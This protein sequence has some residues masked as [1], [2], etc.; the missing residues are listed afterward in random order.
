MATKSLTPQTQQIE[1]ENSERF[2][3]HKEP[4]H[5]HNKD[6]LNYKP[7]PLKWPVLG[8]LFIAI[9]IILALLESLRHTLSLEPPGLSLQTPTSKFST[10][11]MV[12]QTGISTP[13]INI[14]PP[15]TLA[16]GDI[17]LP[18]RLPVPLPSVAP[19]HYGM[20]NGTTLQNINGTA[21]T[22][23]NTELHPS[24]ACGN[25][26]TDGLN[27]RCGQHLPPPN[28]A[29]V[30]KGPIVYIK[31]VCSVYQASPGHYPF[32]EQDS[33]FPCDYS[34]W[35]SDDPSDCHMQ[36]LQ[37]DQ[38]LTYQ[39]HQT[40]NRE[41]FDFGEG[42]TGVQGL[43]CNF[44][45]QCFSYPD[46]VGGQAI[47]EEKCWSEGACKGYPIP[48]R[49]PFSA[50]D[51]QTLSTQVFQVVDS[52][53]GTTWIGGFA[54]T[55]TSII[56]GTDGLST[57]VQT[58]SFSGSVSTFTT[59]E[60]ILI[61]AAKSAGAPFWTAISPSTLEALP[62]GI[63]NDPITLTLRN[64]FGVP[65]GTKTE[66]LETPINSDGS[67]T[68]TLTAILETLTDAKGI[69]TKTIVEFSATGSSVPTN[70]PV[71]TSA[72]EKYVSITRARYFAGSF[73]PVL[74]SVLLSI[75]IQLVDKNL[76]FML[77]FYALTRPKGAS[78]P[79]SLCMIPGGVVYLPR[80]FGLLY[81]FGEP[82]SF[83]SDLLVVLSAFLV[84]LSS[85][86]IGLKMHGE[87]DP[88]D[89]YGG[90]YYLELVMVNGP[91]RVVA[92]LLGL[93]AVV[94][95]LIWIF[96]CRAKSGVAD[97]PWSIANCAS[98]LSEELEDALRSVRTRAKDRYNDSSQIIKQL[99]G[100]SFG[101]RHYS[102]KHGELGYGIAVIED[103]GSSDSDETL[104]KVERP[105]STRFRVPC[106]RSRLVQYFERHSSWD[107]GVRGMLLAILCGLLALILYYEIRQMT[108]ADPFES[109]MDSQKFGVRFFFVAL[110][111]I[112]TLFWDNYVSRKSPYT[113]PKL[114][115]LG[116]YVWKLILFERNDDDATVPI[117]FSVSFSNQIGHLKFASHLSLP[118]AMESGA[119][120]RSLLPCCFICWD[121]IQVHPNPPL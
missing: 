21:S 91:S 53:T 115:L 62:P 120:P 79:D 11:S 119:A 13:K 34:W 78:A 37:F 42:W 41:T 45:K 76:K 84:S 105:G 43:N 100:K 56:T 1:S 29:S 92:A 69:P 18:L 31:A 3:R 25:S 23:N 8:S 66:Y 93:M 52:T 22:E 104:R 51:L 6:F 102:G 116:A 75:V 113:Y 71:V 117:S 4:I 60:T 39:I 101:L 112:V 7:I 58:T 27:R 85:E 26:I 107:H 9:C 19:R 47:E 103:S 106:K 15:C 5:T 32:F 50:S 61:T 14:R 12:Y 16:T 82:L 17:F 88:N 36:L 55:M 83:L 2:W 40:F 24:S 87:L 48:M 44:P 111:V 90:S 10:T 65:T 77:P 99:E 63:T 67:P 70:F 121:L 98:L 110:G 72:N 96:L 54:T 97:N 46:V 118:S 64:Q 30:S 114:G 108:L 74:L 59:S 94:A 73:V 49:F 38:D 89:D 109:F 68:A 33:K 57:T 80:S 81:R 86:A 28:Y 95:V 20:A 35:Y